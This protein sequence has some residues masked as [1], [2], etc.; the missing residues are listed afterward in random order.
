M[1]HRELE[2]LTA[3]TWPPEVDLGALREAGGTRSTVSP[4]AHRVCAMPRAEAVCTPKR[5][6]NSVS[7]PHPVTARCFSQFLPQ[8]NR[9]CNR[10]GCVAEGFRVRN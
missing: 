4:L 8:V 6:E 9:D 3:Q 5:M 2:L 1:S 10:C 7:A